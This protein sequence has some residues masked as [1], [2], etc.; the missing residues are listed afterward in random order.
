MPVKSSPISVR[1]PSW[2]ANPSRRMAIPIARAR[3]VR[4]SL[5]PQRPPSRSERPELTFA[6]MGA[7]A[8][9][10]AL[11]GK[12]ADRDR[13]YSGHSAIASTAAGAFL[14]YLV[15]EAMSESDRISAALGLRRG[16]DL[17]QNTFS[18]LIG[19]STRTVAGHEATGKLP[20]GAL[21][22]YTEVERMQAALSEVMRPEFIGTWLDSP[23]SAFGGSTPLQVIER[24][25]SDRVWAS[26]HRMDSGIS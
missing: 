19:F 7:G 3:S 25:E 13:R 10:G 23:N 4:R 14:G 26:I 6:V 1:R 20:T 24:G 12:L 5:E 22:R 17:T 2:A 8:L 15:Q 18:R 21:R 11:I 9:L 16:L